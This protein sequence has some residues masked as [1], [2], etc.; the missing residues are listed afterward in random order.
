MAFAGSRHGF[1]AFEGLEVP[2]LVL[3]TK[4]FLIVLLR[5]FSPFVFKRRTI[6]RRVQ[7]AIHNSFRRTLLIGKMNHSPV[8][9]VDI[10]SCEESSVS[11]DDVASSPRARSP[12]RSEDS[13]GMKLFTP[14]PFP[15][16]KRVI[17]IRPRE[18]DELTSAVYTSIN[19]S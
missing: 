13:L 14:I 6:I 12:H 5:Q 17:H 11:G 1:L 8:G 9:L 19:S 16:P 10:E 18:H 15:E 4:I 7:S 2:L 3:Q